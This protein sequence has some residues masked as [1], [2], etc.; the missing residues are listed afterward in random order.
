MHPLQQ[1][2]ILVTL[3][4][5]IVPLLILIKLVNHL[6]SS[7]ELTPLVY[8]MKIVSTP[9]NN[10]QS[11]NNFHPPTPGSSSDDTLP[12]DPCRPTQTGL[13]LTI[14][15]QKTVLNNV[16]QPEEDMTPMVITVHHIVPFNTQSL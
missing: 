1:L 6:R 3:L 2:N 13:Q 8:R 9:H 4:L 10:G 12:L 5:C 7:P 11:F 16:S 15:L 14:N